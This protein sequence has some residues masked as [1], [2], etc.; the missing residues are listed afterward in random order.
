MARHTMQVTVDYTK[1]PRS[2]DLL[3]ADGYEHNFFKCTLLRQHFH[4]IVCRSTPYERVV[5][6][7]FSTDKKIIKENKFLQDL[8]TFIQ[9]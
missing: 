7:H 2:V 8:V 3:V 5:F 9:M 4:W 6:V 1:K